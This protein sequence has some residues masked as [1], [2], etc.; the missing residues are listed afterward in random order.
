MLSPLLSTGLRLEGL[1][2]LEEEDD[3]SSSSEEDVEDKG[4]APGAGVEEVP[5]PAEDEPQGHQFGKVIDKDLAEGSLFHLPAAPFPYPGTLTCEAEVDPQAK[6]VVARRLEGGAPLSPGMEGDSGP[7][8]TSD[9]FV[10]DNVLTEEECAMLIA[11]MEASNQLSSWCSGGSDSK[12][13]FR[14][15]DTVETNVP[16]L[17]ELVWRRIRP[18]LENGPPRSSQSSSSPDSKSPLEKSYADKSLLE[19]RY[20]DEEDEDFECD[21]LGTWDCVGV[22]PNW[23]FAR[24]LDGGYFSAHTDGTTTFDFNKRTLYTVLLYLDSCPA[25]VPREELERS[26]QRLGTGL[27]GTTSL[28]TGGQAGTTRIIDARRVEEGRVDV[29]ERMIDAPRTIINSEGGLAPLA[30]EAR[31]ADRDPEPTPNSPL[32]PESENRRPTASQREFHLNKREKVTDQNLVKE[33]LRSGATRLFHPDQIWEDLEKTDTDRMTGSEHNVVDCVFPKAGRVLVF[34]HRA[35]HEGLP[36]ARKHIVRTDLVFQ[37]REKLLTSETDQEAYALYQEAERLAE[38][39][40][41]K[42][43]CEKFRWAFGMSK[44]LRR[45]YKQ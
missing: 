17:A 13:S 33:L 37:R 3:L 32:S 9:G 44:E 12:S 36:S 39:G 28:V 15:A 18:F 45:I 26:H 19:R 14:V 34:Y 22:N 20:E 24:Y 4:A 7:A 35:M 6:K 38:L 21:L 43:A 40:N 10:F 29:V 27:G 25:G 41:N 8:H 16:H 30:A 2:D 1:S 23:L 5:P 42:E 31:P 11:Q